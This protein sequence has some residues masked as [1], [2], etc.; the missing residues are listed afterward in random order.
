M[1][2]LYILT[3]KTIWLCCL[4]RCMPFAAVAQEG[5][6]D[7][8]AYGNE[9][10]RAWL[11]QIDA[12]APYLL[13]D[14]AAREVRLMH[15]QAVLRVCPL[16]SETLGA[17]PDSRSV[18]LARLRRYR[19]LDPWS[20]VE[21]GPFDWEERLVRA[22]PDDGALYFASGLLLCAAEVWQTGVSPLVVVSTQDW[23][24]LYNAC[25]EGTPLVIL[26]EDWQRGG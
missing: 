19:V 11:Q 21:V 7:R 8:L 18:V 10:L 17:M 12:D 24:A 16:Q 26:P 13:V 20:K 14:R 5:A 3:L 4:L 25:T 23:R 15:G 1:P 22:A 6:G 2:R 9:A